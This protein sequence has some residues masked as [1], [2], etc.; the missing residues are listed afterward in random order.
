MLPLFPREEVEN[1]SPEAQYM[2]GYRMGALF[3]NHTDA[4]DPL[5]ILPRFV[6]AQ[7]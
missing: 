5:Q 4:E 7:G 1:W 6:D 3:I 2:G